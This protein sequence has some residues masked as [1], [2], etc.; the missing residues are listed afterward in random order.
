MFTLFELAVV[1]NDSDE[2]ED[3]WANELL[4]MSSRHSHYLK[5]ELNHISNSIS[6]LCREHYILYLGLF[7]KRGSTDHQVPNFI[8]RRFTYVIPKLFE[9]KIF[10]LPGHILPTLSG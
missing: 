6:R 1:K 9:L 8:K 5:H 7:V 2:N 4:L 3:P 10:L